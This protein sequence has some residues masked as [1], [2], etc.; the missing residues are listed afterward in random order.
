M[1]YLGL[2]FYLFVLSTFGTQ[3]DPNPLDTL[4]INFDIKE[5]GNRIENANQKQKNGAHY[6]YYKA[7][8]SLDSVA[9]N[10]DYSADENLEIGASKLG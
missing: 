10:N 6:N 1:S 3:A 8:E 4:N 9:Y 7:E 5:T 2:C